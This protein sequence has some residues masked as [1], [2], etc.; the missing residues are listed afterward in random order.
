M[1]TNIQL[2]HQADL[3]IVK[4]VVK[5]CDTHNLRYFM[6]GG[7]QLGAVRHKGFIPW[8]DD[9]DLGMPRRDYEQFLTIAP[10]LL[11]KNL[12]IVNYRTDPAYHYYITRILDTDSKVIETRF[13][14]EGSSTHLS[15]DIF[16][17]DGSPNNSVLRKLY[18]LRVLSHRAMMS[19]HYKNGIDPDR[20]RGFAE[21]LLLGIMKLIPTDKIFNAQHQK[22]IIDRLLQQYDMWDSKIS[23][24]IMGAYR[25]REM[26]PTE[27]LGGPEGMMF[28]F[29]GLYLRGFKHYEKYLSHLYGD[30]MKLPPENA[31]KVHFRLI[32]IHGRKLD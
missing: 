18:Y 10:N 21:R 6:L 16:P 26:V 1:S 25:S 30:Y 29:E 27:W 5:I 14:N 32:E 13:E 7:T 24:N 19:L 22:E 17:L 20:K 12:R 28:E 4:E 11:S 15:I 23:G 2:L 8:D 9:I 31:R 3:E